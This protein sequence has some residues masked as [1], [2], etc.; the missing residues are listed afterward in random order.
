MVRLMGAGQWN[1]CASLSNTPRLT[2]SATLSRNKSLYSP[3]FLFP[4][5]FLHT[6]V[7]SGTATYSFVRQELGLRVSAISVELATSQLIGH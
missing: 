3:F 4:H 1:T 6:N 2:S 5:S 7:S